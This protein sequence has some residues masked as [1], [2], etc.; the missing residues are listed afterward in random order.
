MTFD[1]WLRRTR[2]GET[3]RCWIVAE[4]GVNH[5]GQLDLALELVDVA[6]R[7][8]ADAVKFQTF[9]TERL[10]QRDAPV[11][12]YQEESQD[13]ASQHSMLRE[14]ELGR[15]DFR[16]LAERC[17]D[18]GIAFLSTPFDRE[19]AQ[20]VADLGVPAIKISSTDLTNLPL[21]ESVAGLGLPVIQSTGMGYL[22]EV[23]DAV[24]ALESAGAEDLVLLQCTSDYPSD[25]KDV[26]LRAMKTLRS[27]GYPVG[28][29]D[30]TLGDH[31]PVA[32]VAHGACLVEKH[33]TLDRSMEG[34][35][36]QASLTPDSLQRMIRKIRDV[37][38]ALGDGRK[39][40]AE[41]ER[42]GRYTNRRGLVTT[43]EVEQGKTLEDKDLA[44]TRPAEGLSPRWFDRVVG[45]SA[46]HKLSSGHPLDWEDLE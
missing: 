9:R 14:L 4:A 3:S 7:A 5:N 27:F 13:H 12:S 40:P 36:H 6:S 11:A 17:R 20:F 1:Q 15:D 19:S 37:E 26:N 46:R 41:S 30:H 32:A 10:V 18:R 24:G 31:V 38:R 33:F 29:S 43:R 44:A 25:P 34:P 28:L 35:D 2:R 23:E 16:R 22:G 45:R 42:G 8:G 21:L 39:Q